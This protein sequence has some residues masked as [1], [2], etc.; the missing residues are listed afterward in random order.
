MANEKER[1]Y[2]EVRKSLTQLDLYYH[3]LKQVGQRLV[4]AAEKTPSGSAAALYEE[5]LELGRDSLRLLRELCDRV[6]VQ[7][8]SSCQSAL[9]RVEMA[10]QRASQARTQTLH[11]VNIWRLIE[12]C[13]ELMDTIADKYG[14]LRLSGRAGPQLTEAE[15]SKAA[16]LAKLFAEYEEVMAGMAEAPRREGPPFT[17]GILRW[18]GSQLFYVQRVE[19]GARWIELDPDYESTSTIEDKE[20]VE[21]SEARTIEG[22]PITL[23]LDLIVDENEVDA[24][25]RSQEGSEYFVSGHQVA[26]D[27]EG[28]RGRTRRRR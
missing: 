27:R 21:I 10:M 25:I 16:E 8:L 19:D 13:D 9:R 22:Y 5:S 12:A 23:R 15:E 18:R 17:H 2:E 4:G 20:A 26:G 11:M 7:D 1:R 3:S 14:C 24:Y 6:D 28:R